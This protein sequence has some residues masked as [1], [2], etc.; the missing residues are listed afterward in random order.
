MSIRGSQALALPLLCFFSLCALGSFS[1]SRLA[2][3]MLMNSMPLALGPL[4]E[5]RSGSAQ[6]HSIE[7]EP[8]RW[9]R[10]GQGNGKCRDHGQ[11]GITIWRRKEFWGGSIKYENWK[12]LFY[13]P[14]NSSCESLQ[15][16]NWMTYSKGG[17]LWP[18]SQVEIKEEGFAILW[19]GA[20]SPEDMG[21]SWDTKHSALAFGKLGS[22]QQFPKPLP[23]KR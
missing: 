23:A 7:W 19:K 11:E 6:K 10:T 14:E 20:R 1:S 15:T 2:P 3:Q 17:A 5:I 22:C 21:F 8:D 4:R 13:S 12:E 18:L 9:S 16:G